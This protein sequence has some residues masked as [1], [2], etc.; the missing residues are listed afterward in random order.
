MKKRKLPINRLFYNNR[1]A[2]VFSIIAAVIIWLVVALF[3]SPEVERVIKNVPVKIEL[4]NNVKTLDL[5]TW[6]TEEYFIDITVFGRRYAVESRVLEAD[7]FFV[8]AKTNYVDSPGAKILQIDVK[9]KSANPNF[10]ITDLSADSIYVYFDKYKEDEYTLEAEIV[11]K[12]GIIP[13]GYY[14]DEEVLSANVVTI[15]GPAT[16]INKIQKVIARVE[17]DE[18]LTSTKTFD[19]EILPVGEF[20]SPLHYLT[21]NGGNENITMTIPVYRIAELPVTVDFKSEPAYYLSNPLKTT[22]TPGRA[23]FGV[24]NETYESIII[25]T[26]DFSLIKPGVNRFTVKAEDIA[27]AKVISGADAFRIEV[28]AGPVSELASRVPAKNITM[29]NISAGYKAALESDGIENITVVGPREDLETITQDDIY[30]E[31]DVTSSNTVTGNA[32]V[33]VKLTIKGSDNC[34]VYGQYSVEVNIS[35]E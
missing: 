24:D 34:W 11:S 12:D 20:S 7:D 35:N 33:P 1:F 19:A 29:V 2:M 17:V 28:D 10:E 23:T 31:A 5:M 27:E 30:A 13:K 16:E 4:S 15:S 21:V 6:G 22:I 32:F 3:F 8:T 18:E 25:D 26:I 14:Q 9:P